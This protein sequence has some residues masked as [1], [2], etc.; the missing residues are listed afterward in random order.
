[1]EVSS[2][3]EGEE[4]NLKVKSHSSSKFKHSISKKSRS[5]SIVHNDQDLGDLNEEEKELL[6]YDWDEFKADVNKKTLLSRLDKAIKRRL[7]LIVYKDPK[8][9]EKIVAFK[10][11]YMQLK[12]IK[13]I[14][15]FLYLALPIFEK[16]GWCIDSSEIAQDSPEGYW[17]CQNEKGT[18]S[19]STIPKL[20]P[21]LTNSTFFVCLIIM[22]YFT[23]ARDKYRVQEN[24]FL[25]SCI[26]WMTILSCLDLLL[27][28]ITVNV[29]KG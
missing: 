7:K 29:W 28:L 11:R 13:Y 10:K 21:N 26:I 8:E 5:M 2:S 6:E 23:L 12:I 19:N 1:M 18:I 14:A 3:D 24:L 17:Y 4:D 22:L 15:I 20:P 9:Q 27:C 16:P 25:R